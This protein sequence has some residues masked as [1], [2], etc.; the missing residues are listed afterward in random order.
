[1][2]PA[3]VLPIHDP[4]GAYLPHLQVILPDLQAHF[5]HAY[6]SLTASTQAHA[7]A[8]ERLRLDPFFTILPFASDEPVGGHFSFLY[9]QAAQAAPARQV[10]HLCFLD[11][12]SFALETEHRL[13]FLADVDALTLADVPLIFHRSPAAWATHPRNYRQ[14]EGFVTQVG[15]TLFGK[16]LDYAWC[17]IVVSAAQL[18]EVMAQTTRT[19][20]SLVAEMILLLQDHVHTRDVDW[21][22]WEDPF[23]L[24]RDPDEYRQERENSLAETEKRLSYVLPMVDLLTRF[25]MNGKRCIE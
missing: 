2:Q 15:E 9:R 13:A 5:E 7:A 10:L 3:L 18:G 14:L 8:V 11:R 22:A 19:D 6:L 25:A 4:Q 21:L 24:G 16:T 12:L 1:M 17:H 23:L 20:L